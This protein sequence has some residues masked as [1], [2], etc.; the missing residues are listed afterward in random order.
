MNHYHIYIYIH[1]HIDIIRFTNE[2]HHFP[3]FQSPSLPGL[4]VA[5]WTAGPCRETCGG[6]QPRGQTGAAREARPRGAIFFIGKQGGP[7]DSM[8]FYWILQDFK[9]MSYWFQSDFNGF[10]KSGD[11]GSRTHIWDHVLELDTSWHVHFCLSSWV[12]RV[13]LWHRDLAIA[14]TCQRREDVDARN[15]NMLFETCFYWQWIDV[16]KVQRHVL[17]NVCDGSVFHEAVCTRKVAW[18]GYCPSLFL[19]LVF[20]VH[21]ESIWINPG[22]SAKSGRWLCECRMG[23]ELLYCRG[24]FNCKTCVAYIYGYKCSGD[25]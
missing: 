14:S 4:A 20:C 8:R 21:D 10:K 23:F 13:T 7:W 6:H 9:L 17:K 11:V 18:M 3:G 16:F 12:T 24:I 5:G 22:I 15:W 2:I 25:P 1:T 19:G